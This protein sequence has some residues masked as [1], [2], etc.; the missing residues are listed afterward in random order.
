[1][2]VKTINYCTLTHFDAAQCAISHLPWW[3]EWAA[4]G[5]IALVALSF[6]QNFMW[7]W[8]IIFVPGLVLIYNVVTDYGPKIINWLQ[9]HWPK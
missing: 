7:L 8:K 5:L 4:W 3:W 2:T 9:K 1:M 6:V